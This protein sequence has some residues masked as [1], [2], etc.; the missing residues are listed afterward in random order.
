MAILHRIVLDVSYLEYY[1]QTFSP[2][3]SDNLLRTLT[4]TLNW[5]QETVKIF[6]KT[7]PSPRLQ[8]FYGEPGISYRYSGRDFHSTPWPQPLLNIKNQ[9]ST[10]TGQPFNAVLCNLYRDGQDAMG[11]HSD[12]EPELGAHPV[13]ASLSLGEQRTFAIRKTKHTRQYLTLPL[14]HNSLLVMPEGFQSLYQHSVPRTKKKSLPR[15][16]LTFRMF[17]N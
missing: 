8:C 13:I 3:E 4:E 9:I 15:I 12:N 17:Y 1:R 16:N 14:D 2:T 5:Q 11:W 6:G 10:L 7:L